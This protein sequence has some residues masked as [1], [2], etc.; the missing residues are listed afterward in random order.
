MVHPPA[1]WYNV[2]FCPIL[3]GTVAPDSSIITWWCPTFPTY[4][5]PLRGA[6]ESLEALRIVQ[7]T[8]LHIGPLLRAE[9]LRGFV[10]RINRL[11]PDLGPPPARAYKG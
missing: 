2:A 8:D 10:K 3:R 7:A 4:P 9:R 11:E 6:T 5:L 1:A